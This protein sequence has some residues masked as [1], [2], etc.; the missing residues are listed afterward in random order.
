MYVIKQNAVIS[1]Q[2]LM[3]SEENNGLNYSRYITILAL[4]KYKVSKYETEKV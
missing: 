2:D 1:S 4:I 3:S